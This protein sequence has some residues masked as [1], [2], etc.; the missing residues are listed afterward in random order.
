MTVFSGE[1]QVVYWVTAQ[2]PKNILFGP[3]FDRKAAWEFA[4]A[5]PG[6]PVDVKYSY[7]ES[8]GDV[9]WARGTI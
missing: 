1:M 2:H 6:I 3:T 9:H 7:L 8:R 5:Q 4:D